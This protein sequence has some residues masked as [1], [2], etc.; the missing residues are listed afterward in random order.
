MG[1][2]SGKA[3]VSV[4]QRR[5][6]HKEILAALSCYLIILRYAVVV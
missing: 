4:T 3:E 1:D 6:S 2:R 5:K